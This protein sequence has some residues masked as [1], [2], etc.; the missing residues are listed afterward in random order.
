MFFID[1]LSWAA[2]FSRGSAFN[3]PTP[4]YFDVR[5]IL[6]LVLLFRI[7]F[8]R[9]TLTFIS[10]PFRSLG[11]GALALFMMF[12]IS[13][14]VS[15]GNFHFIHEFVILLGMSLIMYFYADDP[16]LRKG[17]LISYI[18][19]CLIVS[20]EA[21]WGVLQSGSLPTYHLLS[22]RLGLAYTEK[23]NHNI[24]GFTS[25][26]AAILLLVGI[27][28]VHKK[29]LFLAAML[30]IFISAAGVFFSTSRSA[31]LGLMV[32]SGF[33][34]FFHHRRGLIRFRM[35]T[36][37][38]AFSIALAVSGTLYFALTHLGLDILRYRLINEPLSAMGIQ[39]S[40]RYTD[41]SYKF[42]D[43]AESIKG[44]EQYAKILMRHFEEEP[45]SIFIGGKAPGMELAAHTMFLNIMTDSG[46]FGLGAYI[47]FMVMVMVSFFKYADHSK[48]LAFY[49]FP[50]LAVWIYCQGQNREYMYP[51]MFALAGGFYRELELVKETHSIEKSPH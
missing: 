2:A 14:H 32:T 48:T 18:A 34:L 15:Q 5:G 41:R 1:Y 46:L 44:R 7:A 21:I 27:V 22:Q 12:Y 50:M 38:V 30:G 36:L 23:M 24:F 9:K 26:M 20:L 33:V 35:G 17:I 49:F 4:F 47:L 6:T 16:K 13:G 43:K 25:M 39:E 40:I 31:I 45:L 37:I 19:G 10:L 29:R 42:V 8:T 11:A 28:R 51:V 3:Y